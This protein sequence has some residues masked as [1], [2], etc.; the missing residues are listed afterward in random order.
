M[1]V[2][3]CNSS[4]DSIPRR[5]L[6]DQ[7]L[8]GELTEPP[9]CRPRIEQIEDEDNGLLVSLEVAYSR[10]TRLRVSTLSTKASIE[11]LRSLIS[12]FG[13]ISLLRI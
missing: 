5:I 3:A 2:H 10:P 13:R 9:Y 4:P 12:E 1:L 6:P 11:Q 8:E 7:S